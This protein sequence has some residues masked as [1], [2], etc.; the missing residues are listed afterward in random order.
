MVVDAV[1]AATVMPIVKAN[2]AKEAV[3]MTD[4]SNIYRGVNRHFAAHGTTN[5]SARQYVDYELLAVHSNAV[6]GYFSIFKRA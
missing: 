1:T 4:E 3:G 5:H 2:V 6:E